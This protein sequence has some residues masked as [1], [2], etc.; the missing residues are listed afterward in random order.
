MS[1]LMREALRLAD[2][3]LSGANMNMAVVKRKIAEA[4]A[5]PEQR[6][7]VVASEWRKRFGENP[8]SSTRRSECDEYTWRLMVLCQDMM[9]ALERAAPPAPAVPDGWKLAAYRPA[10]ETCESQCKCGVC[11]TTFGAAPEVPHG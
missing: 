9:A 8:L 5:Q 7:E 3:A 11:G 4:L 6:G 10:F 2:A 1:E